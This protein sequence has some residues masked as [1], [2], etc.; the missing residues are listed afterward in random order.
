M[1]SRSAALLGLAAAFLIACG[2]SG[3]DRPASY[4]YIQSAI[5]EPSC[6]T[7]ACHSGLSQVAEI[8]FETYEES[9]ERL[10]GR[11]CD[12]DDADTRRYVNPGSPE[13][14]QLMYLLLGVEVSTPMPPDVRI[15]DADID[16]IERWILEGAPCN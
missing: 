6:A 5:L 4:R 3:D 1:G 2:D 16:L 12:D 11:S 8:D 15:P 14:S 10:T 7:S 13:N 9:Y